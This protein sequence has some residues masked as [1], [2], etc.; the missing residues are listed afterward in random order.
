VAL[1]RAILIALGVAPRRHSLQ[2]HRFGDVFGRRVRPD[3]RRARRNAFQPYPDEV[4]DI[5]RSTFR[6]A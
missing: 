6:S 3:G 5:M 1:L 2:R 4:K